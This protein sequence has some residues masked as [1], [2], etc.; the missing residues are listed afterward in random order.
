MNADGLHLE[1]F[2]VYSFNKKSNDYPPRYC[3]AVVLFIIAHSG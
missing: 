3:Y 2:F 1:V